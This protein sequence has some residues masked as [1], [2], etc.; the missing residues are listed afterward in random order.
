MSIN[1]T[2]VKQQH[3]TVSK[4]QFRQF[5]TDLGFT[6]GSGYRYSEDV[7]YGDIFGDTWVYFRWDEKS[8]KEEASWGFVVYVRDEQIDLAEFVK[9]GV[10]NEE[11]RRWTNCDH[12][13]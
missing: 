8:T 13:F 9:R 2:A 1:S 10:K 7:L 3:L 6:Q 11:L 4:E 5:L 12:L